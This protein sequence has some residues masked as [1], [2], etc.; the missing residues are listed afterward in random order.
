MTLDTRHHHPCSSLCGI[1]PSV[2]ERSPVQMEAATKVGFPRALWLG[3]LTLT[4]VAVAFLV[5]RTQRLSIEPAQVTLPADGAEHNALRINFPRSWFRDTVS[6][7][8]NAPKLRLLESRRG[9]L[10]GVL[11]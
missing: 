2:V 9:T 4:L 5:Y 8:L 6:E 1:I 7:N 11:L 10:E 3:I